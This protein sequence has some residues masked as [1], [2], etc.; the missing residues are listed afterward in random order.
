MKAVQPY[1]EMTEIR[2]CYAI[3]WYYFCKFSTAK[4]FQI[5]ILWRLKSFAY[6]EKICREN[7][8]KTYMCFS[9]LSQPA[10]AEMTDKG[11]K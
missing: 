1:A 3:F 4:R 6:P 8:S 10:E 9:H 5:D 11:P 2:H 7:S